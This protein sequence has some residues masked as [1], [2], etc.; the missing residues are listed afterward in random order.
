LRIFAK[1]DGADSNRPPLGAPRQA[2]ACADTPRSAQA[3]RRL[4]T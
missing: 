4:A 2:S 1:W 3:L